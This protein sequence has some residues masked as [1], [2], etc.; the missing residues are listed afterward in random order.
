MRYLNQSTEDNM[1]SFCVLV[2]NGWLAFSETLP[3]QHRQPYASDTVRA[4]LIN[5]LSPNKI[6]V[7]KSTFHEGTSRKAR[8]FIR[9]NQRINPD[10]NW[11][12]VGKSLGGR[13]LITEVLNPLCLD[14]T[15]G[16]EKGRVAVVIIDANWPSYF[17]P[18]RNLNNTELHLC[19]RLTD[20]SLIHTFFQSG[21]QGGARLAYPYNVNVTQLT[22]VDHFSI[23]KH[24][25]I[26]RTIEDLARRINGKTKNP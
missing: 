8:R 23:V 5:D 19:P 12:F 1:E 4:V 3:I 17:H 21:R 25:R 24:K 6:L 16:R 13:Q 20:P 11:L 14:G 7:R 2:L 10:T 15:L 22:G 9:M 26:Y 18:I